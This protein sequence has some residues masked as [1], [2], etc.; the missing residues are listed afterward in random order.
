MN[1][2]RSGDSLYLI[3]ANNLGVH[4]FIYAFSP[5]CLF[6]T[7]KEYLERYPGNDW[8]D[9]VGVDNYN[10]FGRYGRYNVDSGIAKLKIVS[11]YALKAGKLPLLQK[12]DWSQFPTQHGG[13]KHCSKH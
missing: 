10:D 11:D 8:V 2:L 1:S 6:R 7:E 9:M 5:D 12:Q 13:R 3:Y 4:N